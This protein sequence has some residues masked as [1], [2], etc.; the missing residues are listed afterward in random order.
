[1]SQIFKKF[2]RGSF[3][4]FTSKEDIHTKR[5]NSVYRHP[6]SPLSLSFSKKKQSFNTHGKELIDNAIQTNPNTPYIEVYLEKGEDLIVCD[7]N[8]LSDPFCNL[9]L[10]SGINTTE[11]IKKESIKVDDDEES[12]NAYILTSNYIEKTLFPEWNETFY[13]PISKMRQDGSILEKLKITVWDFDRITNNDYMGEIVVNLQNLIE[14]ETKLYEMKLENVTSGKLYFKISLKNCGKNIYKENISIKELQE[15]N[16]EFGKLLYCKPTKSDL[17]TLIGEGANGKVW[18]AKNLI[19]N[20]IIALKKVIC[21]KKIFSLELLNE[22]SLTRNLN[23]ENIVTFKNIFFEEIDQVNNSFTVCFEMKLFQNG[24]LQRYLEIKKK[25]KKYPNLLRIINYLIQ[26]GNA[27]KYLN[28]NN[29]I[30]FDIKP[31]NIFLD[32]NYKILKLGDYSFTR[33]CNDLIKNR[34]D[35]ICCGSIPFIAPE[36]INFNQLEILRNNNNNLI[37]LLPKVDIYSFGVVAYQ[38]IALKVYLSDSFYNYTNDRIE[39]ELNTNPLLNEIN[40]NIKNKIIKLVMNC[41]EKNIEKRLSI[42]QLMNELYIV[43]DLLQKEE[44]TKEEEAI[45]V[46]EVNDLKI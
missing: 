12:T 39:K 38:L 40:L 3:F 31:Q 21:E 17:I 37:Q 9:N 34:N 24:D 7:I 22:I 23:H 2:N 10:T 26:L 14:N 46:E 32:E 5:S 33:N 42:N 13:F 30:H 19:T 27:I 43:K 41:L 35:I 36:L 16:L 11:T 18:K 6:P 8:G 15:K 29:L 20:E 25:K 45:I 4:N 44:E 28:E 1:M